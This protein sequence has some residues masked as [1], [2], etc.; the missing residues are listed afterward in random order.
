MKPKKIKHIPREEGDKL[1]ILVMPHGRDG[2]SFY[3]LIQPYKKIFDLGLAD[4][5]LVKAEDIEKEDFLFNNIPAAD[6]IVCRSG[7][8]EW[9]DKFLYPH[10]E[11]KEKTIVLD[12]DDDIYDISPYADVYA[13]HGTSEVEHIKENGEKIKLWE[14]GKAGFDIKRN[15]EKLKLVEKMC[16]KVD[17]ITVSTERLKERFLKFNENVKV[18]PNGLN[19][20]EWKP[21]PLKKDKYFRIGWSGGST[22]YIDLMLIKKPL[23]KF[24][25]K[26]KDTKFIVAGQT[27]KGFTK[28]MPRDRV[29]EYG[30][31]DIDAHPYRTA[32]MNLDVAVIPLVANT[33]NSYKSCIKWYEFSSLGV[34]CICSNYPPYSD[35]V[36][37]YLFNNEKELEELLELAYKGKL[38]VDNFVNTYRDINNIAQDLFN[39]YDNLGKKIVDYE[40]INFVKIEDIDNFSEIMKLGRDILNRFGVKWWLGFGTALGLYRDKDYIKGDTDI[41]VSV[42]ANENTPFDDIIKEFKKHFRPLRAVYNDGKLNQFA[43]VHANGLIYDICFHY[44][45]GDKLVSHADTGKWVDDKRLFEDPQMIQTKYG[46]YPFP[47]PIEDY[48]VAR[49]GDWRTPK[50]DTHGGSIKQ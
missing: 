39:M 13:W 18:V 48:L 23:E 11:T 5:I 46:K 31:K 8:S 25:K 30:W 6:V 16:R 27:W 38:K 12:F 26:H 2:C 15:V 9:L 4:V 50:P 41:D 33:F 21:Y 29:E 19:L 40:S 45:E 34:P 20:D 44:E 36:V 10:Y 35:E 42:W 24:L 22:H 47:N 1:R 17:L 32:L 3:R 28:D 37:N 14:D 49:Y 7:H 43:F